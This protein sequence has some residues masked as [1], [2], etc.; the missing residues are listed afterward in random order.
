[1]NIIVKRVVEIAAGVVV[2]N[3][4]AKAVDGVVGLAKKQV[5][6]HK[7]KEAAN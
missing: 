4:A 5:N 6:D 2:G 7:K 1:M 3:L